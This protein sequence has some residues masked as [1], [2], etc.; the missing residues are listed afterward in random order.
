MTVYAPQW[1]TPAPST[2]RPVLPISG[3]APSQGVG[4]TVDVGCMADRRRH[5]ASLVQC[6]PH[7]WLWRMPGWLELAGCCNT[8]VRS[9]LVDLR[10]LDRCYAA[11]AAAPAVV[12]RRAT[13][14]RFLRWA[15]G[16]VEPT[17]GSG[18]R[19]VRPDPARSAELRKRYRLGGGLMCLSRLV[20]RKGRLPVTALP[21]ISVANRVGDC[22][23]RSISRDV[24][25]AGHD[26]GVADH[27]FAAAWQPTTSRPPRT[28]EVLFAMPCRTPRHRDERR[29]P[30]HRV[31]RSATPAGVRNRR[32]FWRAPEAVQHNKTEASG[33]HWSVDRVADAVAE[34]SIRI[35]PS[36]WAPPARME[37]RVA[38][39]AAAAKL[40]DFLRGDDG[41]LGGRGGARSAIRL[42]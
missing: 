12:F 22:R 16:F 29:E 35:G 14:S 38:L 32:Q 10:S 2:A 9:G 37:R 4:P 40:A 15:R 28:G 30:R 31:P 8:H 21:S 27:V 25:Q 26:C 7:R 34:T 24:A 18:Y 23:R 17:A 33:R 3:G 41:P 39:D 11:S 19:P 13:R 36:R 1:K 42:L 6:G 20:P 5:R